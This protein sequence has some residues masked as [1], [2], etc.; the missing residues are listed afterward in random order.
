MEEPVNNVEEI[1][2][3]YGHD[4]DR[5]Y[6]VLNYQLDKGNLKKEV[7]DNGLVIYHNPTPVK[8]HNL[9]HDNLFLATVDAKVMMRPRRNRIIRGEVEWVI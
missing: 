9:I 1:I 6:A 5:A 7:M 2:K 8:S 4:W 3:L